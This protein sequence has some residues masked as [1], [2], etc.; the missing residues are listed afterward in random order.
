MGRRRRT[1]IRWRSCLGWRIKRRNRTAAWVLIG[2]G[3]VGG[4]VIVAGRKDWS[5]KRAGEMLRDRVSGVQGLWLILVPFAAIALLAAFMPP[6][7]LWGD[8]PNGYDVVEYHL[9]V[10]REWFEAGRIVPLRHNVFSYFPFNV[11]MH[12]LLAM[13]L[14]GGPW[15]GMFLAQLMHVA[16]V[17]LSLVAI[18]GAARMSSG[19][20]LAC[21]ATLAAAA[22]PWI[23]M[24]GAGAFNE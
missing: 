18:Y 1:W 8:E 13:H 10:P 22:T 2:L 6:G 16:M 11:E 21:V 12:Y 4:A 7:I 23:S 9:Q 20:P 17:G 14:R 5:L 15:A 24:L 19:R 3:L